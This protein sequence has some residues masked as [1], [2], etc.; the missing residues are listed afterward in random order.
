[1]VCSGNMSAKPASFCNNDCYAKNFLL[2]CALSKRGATKW[3]VTYK[4]TYAT[5]IELINLVKHWLN[6]F[7]QEDA[8]YS[9][10]LPTKIYFVLASK[11]SFFS[12]S[13]GFI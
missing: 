6:V 12:E 4:E 1:M 7:L 5:F 11:E 3:F 9:V 8:G 10:V 2:N 13:Q